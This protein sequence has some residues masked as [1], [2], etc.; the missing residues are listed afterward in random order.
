MDVLML[1]RCLPRISPGLRRGDDGD[2]YQVFVCCVPPSTSMTGRPMRPHPKGGAWA[3]PETP[4]RR[5]HTREKA[6]RPG[7]PAPRRLKLDVALSLPYRVNKHQH[8][9]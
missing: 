6:G 5:S 8:M 7:R 4:V 1:G 3:S 9:V 2:F